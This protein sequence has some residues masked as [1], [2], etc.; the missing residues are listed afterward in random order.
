MPSSSPSSEPSSEPSS[1]PSSQPSSEPSSEPS[2]VP[3][4][5][6]SSSPSS[7][8]SSLP[9][10]GCISNFTELQDALVAANCPAV[11]TI[12]LCMGTISFSDNVNEEEKCF[13]MTCPEPPCTLDVGDFEFE[14]INSTVSFDGITFMVSKQHGVY[15]CKDCEYSQQTSQITSYAY[16]L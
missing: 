14:F 1:L 4:L 7:E 10:I 16:S 5:E 2:M 8:P 11:S 3:S 13:N 15:Y 12:E 9:S 6:P